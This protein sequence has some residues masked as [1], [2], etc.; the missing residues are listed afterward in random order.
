MKRRI[1]L[2][3]GVLAASLALLALLLRGDEFLADVTHQPILE[4]VVEGG[5]G[6]DLEAGNSR[7]SIRQ[8]TEKLDVTYPWYA[9]ER[10]EDGSVQQVVAGRV[11]LPRTS[12]FDEG[13]VSEEPRLVYYVRGTEQPR[14]VVRADHAT[15]Y[16]QNLGPQNLQEQRDPQFQRAI[17][18]GAVEV[19]L[20]D[21]SGEVLAVLNTTLADLDLR[22]LSGDQRLP[23]VIC[24]EPVSIRRADDALV[25]SGSSGVF[26]ASGRRVEFQAPVRVDLLP[27]ELG[28]G[29]QRRALPGMDPAA[30]VVV[31]SQGAM[32]Y[33]WRG[34]PKVDDP[35]SEGEFRAFF[36]NGDLV[37]ENE[38]R[39][40]QG[41]FWIESPHLEIGV[42]RIAEPLDEVMERLPDRPGREARLAERRSRYE[43]RS[44]VARD[45]T[46]QR[47]VNFGLGDGEGTARSV[48]YFHVRGMLDLAG[49]VLLEHWLLRDGDERLVVD[50]LRADRRLIIERRFDQATADGANSEPSVADSA[51]P[52]DQGAAA[53]DLGLRVDARGAAALEL[54]NRTR[55]S[56]ETLELL[57][58]RV[59]VGEERTRL[60]LES[61]T[62]RQRAALSFPASVH[63]IGAEGTAGEIRVYADPTREGQTVELRGAASFDVEGEHEDLPISAVHIDAPY[64]ELFLP[65]DSGFALDV[66][67]RAPE[68]DESALD[69]GEGGAGG[70]ADPGA[71]Q[72]AATNPG[73]GSSDNSEPG[74]EVAA[75]DETAPPA[76]LPFELIVPE[77]ENADFTF[78]DT[79]ALGAVVTGEGEVAAPA[80]EDEAVA[81]E[82]GSPPLRM[83]VEPQ[84]SCRLE[85]DADGVRFQGRSHYDVQL[86]GNSQR[87]LECDEFD[88][89]QGEE[90]Q[91]PLVARGAVHF[92][93]AADG[94]VVDCDTARF[95]D[96]AR[97]YGEP[98]VVRFALEGASVPAEV[99]GDLVD[100]EP[101]ERGFVAHGSRER[102]ARLELPAELWAGLLAARTSSGAE[103]AKG[104]ATD[105]PGSANEVVATDSAEALE[106]SEGGAATAG[107]QAA[108]EPRPEDETTTSGVLSAMELRLTPADD[109]AAVEP[110][111]PASD[112]ETPPLLG[113]L[114]GTGRVELEDG[115][116]GRILAHLLVADLDRNTLRLDA[117]AADPADLVVSTRPVEGWP[118]LQDRVV[119][120][121]LDV[122]DAGARMVLAPAAELSFH[123]VAKDSST[124]LRVDVYLGEEIEL[125]GSELTSSGGVDIYLRRETGDVHVHCERIEVDFD[126][127]FHEGGSPV[128]IR[129]Q[130]DVVLSHDRLRCTGSLLAFDFESGWL[131][132]KSGV[133]PCRVVHGGE[134]LPVPLLGMDAVF[135]SLR[136]RLADPDP[137]PRPHEIPFDDLLIEKLALVPRD[138]VA[139]R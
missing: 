137:K 40:E 46:E 81:A 90:S 45:P 117:N 67:G 23:P 14:A 120:R 47:V 24:P 43:L 58:T 131:E 85:A 30:P 62:L 57:L 27:A 16:A 60:A 123:P 15:V 4:Q 12:Y 64:A 83:F 69:A 121:W 105:M 59:P 126:R 95:G 37:F 55:A 135:E 99:R 89:A 7:I 82:A 75:A 61:L 112:E 92:E 70:S 118:T 84:A 52:P 132:L 6:F 41:A 28:G 2:F 21:E 33:E 36:G 124:P 116:G 48:R 106:A 80:I 19:E 1:L 127:P 88:F 133:E 34:N 96:R 42:Q 13:L 5:A 113:V 103:V 94:V 65:A 68:G 91:D 107:A 35:S 51:S 3:V 54:E 109:T 53:E 38:V 8:P 110:T 50:E 139:I 74:G 29:V 39:I 20:Y 111:A 98:A 86:E 63:G 11:F 125:N 76:V 130:R 136:F 87:T 25:L 66:A 129:A 115:Q 49:P 134:N 119:A 97:M 102:R 26:D 79:S 100:V 71:G 122:A 108:D 77:L 78:A 44:L 32:T 138:G 10:A 17:L 93:Q 18:R 128:A 73:A 56:S 104:T 9:E 22:S 72:L 114:T 31:R 101:A